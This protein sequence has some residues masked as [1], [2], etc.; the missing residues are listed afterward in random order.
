MRFSAATARQRVDPPGNG[1][2]MIT[3]YEARRMIVVQPAQRLA[4]IL[5]APGGPIAQ[6]GVP[7]TGD[8]RR[9]GQQTIA[10]FACTDWNTRDVSGRESIVC[11]TADGVML[12]AMQDNRVLVQA[13]HIEEVPQPAALFAIPDGDRTQTAPAR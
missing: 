3:D 10:G 11:L 1:T 7:A 4:T 6:H 9:L 13:T 8:Y 12:R 2:Y 5:P